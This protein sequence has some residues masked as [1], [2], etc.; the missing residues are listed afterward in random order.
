MVHFW[1]LFIYLFRENASFWVLPQNL[2]ISL[3]TVSKI[4][5][6]RMNVQVFNSEVPESFTET[7]Y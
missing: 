6:G 2:F 1:G 3:S 5:G 7:K 4:T